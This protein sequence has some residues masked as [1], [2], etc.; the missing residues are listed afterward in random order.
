MKILFS[1]R[2][3]NEGFRNMW[4][5]MRFFYDKF[6][7]KDHLQ[8]LTGRIE[9]FIGLWKNYYLTSDRLLT[10]SLP[11]L[12]R[13]RDWISSQKSYPDMRPYTNGNGPKGQ[14]G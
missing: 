5:L 13:L 14:M 12:L 11:T 10:T 8:V 1:I 4:P 7:H 9:K 2:P 3:K 6:C